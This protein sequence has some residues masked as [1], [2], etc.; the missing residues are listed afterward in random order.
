MNWYLKWYLPLPAKR[1]HST[2]YSILFLKK[3][4]RKKRKINRLPSSKNPLA[5]AVDARDWASI[6]GAGRSPGAGNGNPLRILA[7]RIP[8][9][10]EPGGLQFTESQ[11]IWRNW[12]TKHIHTLKGKLSSGLQFAWVFLGMESCGP[13]GCCF[14]DLHSTKSADAVAARLWLSASLHL[15]KGSDSAHHHSLSLHPSAPSFDLSNKTTFDHQCWAP[16]Q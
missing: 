5:E 2:P 6:P 10:E 3:K 9:T 14:E 16:L 8:G 13:Q 11:R 4:K 1:F 7:W 12:G 15:L